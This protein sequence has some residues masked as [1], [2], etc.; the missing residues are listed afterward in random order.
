[1]PPGTLPPS[2]PSPRVRKVDRSWHIRCC[3]L[4]L[5]P[6]PPSSLEALPA[7]SLEAFPAASPRAAPTPPALGSEHRAMATKADRTRTCTHK[8]MRFNFCKIFKRQ[9]FARA[10]R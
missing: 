1:M 10:Q 4:L 8:I 3:L 9:R 7:A 2:H 5:S 6:L